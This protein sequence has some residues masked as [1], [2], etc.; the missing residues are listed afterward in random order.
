MSH[1]LVIDGI[2]FGDIEADQ[3]KQ[4]YSAVPA[5][6]SRR[7]LASGT[8][9]VQSTHAEKLLTTITGIGVLPPGLG[10]LAIDQT[11]TLKCVGY[12]TVSSTLYTMAS[13]LPSKR[14][15]VPVI[16][17]AWISGVLVPWDGSS[18]VSAAVYRATYVPE[19][20]AALTDRRTDGQYLG[21]EWN[22]SLTFEEV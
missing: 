19:I 3:I 20:T 13:S 17:S 8:L 15:D 18:D 9:L 22:W 12:R 1:S 6:V 10:A 4:T 21:D 11:M 2:H 5:G 7:R 14:A 16:Y